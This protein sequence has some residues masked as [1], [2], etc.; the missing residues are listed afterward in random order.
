MAGAD[1]EV[2]R[3]V[4]VEIAETRH[5]RP[6]DVVPFE[7]GGKRAA[8]AGEFLFGSHAAIGVEVHQIDG[9]G[10]GRAVIIED[11]SDC[12]VGH[13]I[14]IEITNSSDG[15]TKAIAIIENGS[16]S[17]RCVTDFLFG[18]HRAVRVQPQ[19]V[20]GTPLGA[21]VAVERISHRDVEVAITIDVA[22]IG[23]R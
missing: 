2:D 13:T 9:A 11:R 5:C 14:A 15:G 22:E 10:T 1:S 4:A 23:D 8:S 20:H 7:F 3:P 21:T 12:Q 18:L 19:D 17:T 6:Q 16:Q